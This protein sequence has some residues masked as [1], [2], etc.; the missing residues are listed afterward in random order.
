MTLCRRFL[1]EKAMLVETMP[2]S[3]QR[4]STHRSFRLSLEIALLFA[5]NPRCAL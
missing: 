4:P 3:A 1:R 5:E 2:A